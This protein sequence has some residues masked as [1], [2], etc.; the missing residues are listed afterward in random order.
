MLPVDFP[1]HRQGAD[2][3]RGFGAVLDVFRMPDL[4]K[5][6]KI[7]GTL[8]KVDIAQHVDYSYICINN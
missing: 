2:V 6:D 8:D 4:S 5:H 1:E 3:D 7:L